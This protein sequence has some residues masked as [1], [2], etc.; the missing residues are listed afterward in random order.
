MLISDSFP[1]RT[2]IIQPP[3]DTRVLLGH[4]ATLQCKVSSDPSVKFYLDWTHNRQRI[5]TTQRIN[6]L[7]DGTL[8]IQAVR[9]A[10]VGRYECTVQS[11][12]GNET[13]SA[14]LSV[15]ELPYSPTNVKAE[16]LDTK[17]QRAVNISWTPGFDGNSPTKQ[18]IVQKRE[19]PELG[20]I[21]DPFLNW[22]TELSNVSADQRWVLLT[23]L[24]AAAAYQFRVSAV[25]SVGEGTPSDAS[26]V[27]VLPQ[28]GK[29]SNR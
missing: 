20:P 2:Q 8:E 23:N 16:K 26:N 15:I 24:K 10:D 19:V 22:I 4:T 9:A 29:I 7:R 3:A 1:V 11:S 17:S 18:F 28:E 13:R 6:I 14:Q 25:N 21:P 5:Q 27:V 12:G